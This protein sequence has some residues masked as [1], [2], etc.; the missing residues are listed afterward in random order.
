MEFKF[1]NRKWRISREIVHNPRHTRRITIFAWKYL[2]KMTPSTCVRWCS[3]LRH[4]I[5]FALIFEWFS[6]WFERRNWNMQKWCDW[7][8]QKW[9]DWNMQKRCDWNSR[10]SRSNATLERYARTLD[11]NTTYEL[12][13]KTHR[14]PKLP[15][16]RR[17]FQL[18]IV[19]LVKDLN[20][21]RRK[22]LPCRITH[23]KQS[24]SNHEI[25]P[26]W[27]GWWVDL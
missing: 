8:I 1:A 23:S 27:R 13:R 3:S 6:F 22:T 25:H 15:I 14:L 10:A 11:S 18:I 2:A 21:S 9:C 24:S 7:N 17:C 5:E 19:L 26:A 12:N 4:I 20:D 16:C